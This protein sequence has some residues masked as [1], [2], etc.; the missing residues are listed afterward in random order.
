MALVKADNVDNNEDGE[1]LCKTTRKTQDGE[2]DGVVDDFETTDEK[3]GTIKE[4][5]RK[6]KGSS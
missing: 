3:M 5:S 4:I 2:G 6:V 1:G